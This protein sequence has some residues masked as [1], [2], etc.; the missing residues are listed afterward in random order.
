ME[1]IELCPV[2]SLCCSADACSSYMRFPD[3]EEVLVV[4][5]IVNRSP[6][7]ANAVAIHGDSGEPECGVFRA[8]AGLIRNWLRFVQPGDD[9]QRQEGSDNRHE[10]VLALKVSGC[11]FCS[12]VCVRSETRALLHVVTF[13]YHMIHAQL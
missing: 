3:G 9:K 5:S 12:C 10:L 6:I 4:E 1:A 13:E 11:D 7:L 2:A 8:P